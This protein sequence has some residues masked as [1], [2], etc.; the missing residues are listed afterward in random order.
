MYGKTKSILL[1]V[2][3]KLAATRDIPVAEVKGLTHE[4][5]DVLQDLHISLNIDADDQ[6]KRGGGGGGAGSG[7]TYASK[8]R[9][10]TPDTAVTFTN[11]NGEAW[12]DY[13][14]SK[15]DGSVKPKFP[16]FK[17]AD[18]KESVYEFG[19]NGEVN[20]DFADLVSAVEA[21]NSLTATF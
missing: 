11:K 4:Y 13:R 14:A 8:P 5:Y 2:A 19:L 1:Q 9:M 6:P 3:F 17:S 21:F 15:I 16:D 12:I 20:P 10:A 7:Q 18:G